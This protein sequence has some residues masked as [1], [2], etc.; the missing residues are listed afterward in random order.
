[1]ESFISFC[2]IVSNFPERITNVDVFVELILFIRA[3]G[4]L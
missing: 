4:N 2:L 3:V 1:M